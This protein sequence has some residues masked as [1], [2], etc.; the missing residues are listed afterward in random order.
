KQIPPTSDGGPCAFSRGLG[1]RRL[2][3]R[4]QESMLLALTLFEKSWVRMFWFVTPVRRAATDRSTRT[5][6]TKTCFTFTRKPQG[7][8]LKRFTSIAKDTRFITMYQLRRPGALCF[9]RTH[10]RQDLNSA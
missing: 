2:E 8:P 3:R 9:F 5:A 4:P 10:P 1:T 7:S 6:I